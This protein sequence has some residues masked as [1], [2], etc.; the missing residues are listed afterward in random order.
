MVV[1]EV[2]DMSILVSDP[3]VCGLPG[4]AQQFAAVPQRQHRETP[5]RPH[6]AN[7]QSRCHGGDRQVYEC[8]PTH[9]QT[10]V[11]RLNVV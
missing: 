8:T 9:G 3:G 11:Q 1:S 5:P 6:Y 10:Y 4:S 2:M 7:R